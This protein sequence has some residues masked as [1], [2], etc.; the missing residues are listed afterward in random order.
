MDVS[1]SGRNV[2]LSPALRAAVERKVGSLGRYLRGVSTATVHFV[3]ER[4]RRIAARD[5]VEVTI[6]GNG[7]HLRAKVAAGDP[8]AAVD[9]AVVKLEHQLRRVKTKL[10]SRSHPRRPAPTVVDPG[11]DEE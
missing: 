3:E 8:F 2:E 6:E 11:E 9:A 1:V 7:H 5:V 4:N 10:V